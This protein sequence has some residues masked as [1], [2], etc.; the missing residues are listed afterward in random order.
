M[1]TC[2]YYTFLALETR[3]CTLLGMAHVTEKKEVQDQTLFVVHGN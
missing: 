3:K 1:I 2:L